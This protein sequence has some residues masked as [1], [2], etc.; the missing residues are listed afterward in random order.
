MLNAEVLVPLSSYLAQ[1]QS[2]QE[3]SLAVV[4][5]QLTVVYT[6]QSWRNEIINQKQKSR[7]EIKE[8][9]LQCPERTLVDKSVSLKLAEGAC[10]YMGL[11]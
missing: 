11:S 2:N 8:L 4:I 9:L 6:T 7:I 10:N 3:I 5:C 1:K